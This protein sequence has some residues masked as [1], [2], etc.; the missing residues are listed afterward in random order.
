[1]PA[2]ASACMCVGTCRLLTELCKEVAS[3]SQSLGEALAGALQKRQPPK[4]AAPPKQEASEAAAATAVK[5][6]GDQKEAAGAGA[7]GEKEG[8]KEAEGEEEPKGEAEAVKAEEGQ[9][10]PAVVGRELGCWG[11]QCRGMQ[12]EPTACGACLPVGVGDEAPHS[13]GRLP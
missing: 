7:D 12:C 11:A 10:G 2:D 5:A 13:P 1:M 4:A 3:S 6:E 9:A 8:K